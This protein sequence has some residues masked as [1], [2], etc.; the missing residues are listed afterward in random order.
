M[1]GFGGMTDAIDTLLATAGVSVPTWFF[2]ALLAIGFAFLF[3]HIRQNQR[4]QRARE[5]IQQR[6]EQGGGTQPAFREE[7]LE[8]ANGHPTTLLVIATEAYKR[9]LL[10]LSKTALTALERTGKHKGDA[11]LLRKQLDGPPRVHPQAEVAAIEMLCS[12]GLFIMAT[13]RLDRA[14]QDWPGLE[15]WDELR[16]NILSEE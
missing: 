16:D 11:R 12:Q 6:A 9:G 2:P 15:I 5:R 4:T 13:K 1:R 8:L 14:K 10:Q 3:P 7:L